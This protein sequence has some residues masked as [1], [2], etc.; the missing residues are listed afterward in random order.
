VSGGDSALLG[1]DVSKWQTTTPSLIGIDFLI[2]RAGIGTKLDA[3]YDMHIANARKAA[4]VTGSYWFNWGTLSVSDQVAAYARSEG[5][6]DLHVIDWEGADGFTAAQTADFIRRY[7]ALTGNRIGLYASE[8]RFRDLGQDWDWIANY[9]REPIKHYDIWQYGPYHGADGN[10]F[11][12]TDK[13]ILNDAV[14][15]AIQTGVQGEKSRL[16]VLLGL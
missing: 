10:R 11:P 15:T 16:R 8:S 6:V 4:I 2:A 3:Y 5:D 7:R 1:V 13:L 9:S 14:G 12:G